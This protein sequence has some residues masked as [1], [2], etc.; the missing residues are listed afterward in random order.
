MHYKKR[1]TAKEP[2]MNFNIPKRYLEALGI[3]GEFE[4]QSRGVIA[5][6]CFNFFRKEKDGNL[7]KLKRKY[8]K[9]AKK[10]NK[11]RFKARKFSISQ[12]NEPSLF[13]TAK[14]KSLENL[15]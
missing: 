1:R 2:S 5:E 11:K 3:L 14:A 7:A 6:L 10:S 12:E 15:G 8:Y 9:R 4:G 13:A